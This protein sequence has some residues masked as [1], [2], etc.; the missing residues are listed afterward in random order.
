MATYTMPLSISPVANIRDDVPSG[1]KL[2][3]AAVQ[4]VLTVATSSDFTLA[5][6]GGGSVTVSILYVPLT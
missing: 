5:L 2:Q 4:P 1:S 3:V 6:S